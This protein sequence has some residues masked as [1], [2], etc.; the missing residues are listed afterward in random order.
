MS[1]FS[2]AVSGNR[3]SNKMCLGIMY[4]GNFRRNS[5]RSDLMNESWSIGGVLGTTHNPMYV[6]TPSSLESCVVRLG[7]TTTAVEDPFLVN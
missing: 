3:S 2:F 5:A 6:L 1:I 7:F 4:V